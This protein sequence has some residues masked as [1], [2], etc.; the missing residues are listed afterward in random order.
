MTRRALIELALFGLPFVV[1]FLYR[2]ASSDMSIK[3]KWPLTTL[4]SIGAV[5]AVGALIIPP[6][7][8]KPE[9]TKCLQAGRFENGV[10]QPDQY[11]EC[12]RFLEPREDAPYPQSQPDG[13]TATE[14]PN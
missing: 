3:D 6:L 7:L 10:R 9:G 2:A 13:A 8:E 12:E 5:I 14:G 4:V 1:F 11:V